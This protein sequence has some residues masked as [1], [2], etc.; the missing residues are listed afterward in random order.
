MI[1]MGVEVEDKITGFKGIVTGFC[2]YISGCNQVLVQPRLDKD[3][4]FVEGRWLDEQR[5]TV[6]SARNMR[7]TL[8]NTETPGFDLL[9]P[10]R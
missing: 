4:K 3:E 7:V 2:T 9:P 6:I 1:P 8:D 10:T 5:L